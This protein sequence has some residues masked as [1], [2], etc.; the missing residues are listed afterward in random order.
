M[1]NPPAGDGS[2]P[3]PAPVQAAAAAP[4]PSAPAAAPAQAPAPSI[5]APAPAQP[6]SVAAPA[7]APAPSAAAAAPGTPSE[8]K[9]AAHWLLM[10]AR[11]QI[12]L[13]NYDEAMQKVEQARALHIRWG[14]FD[15]TPAKVAQAIERARPKAVAV[16]TPDQPRDR[17]AA[18]ARLKEARALLADGRYEQAEALALDVKGWGLSYGLFEDSPSKVAAAA[19]ALRRREEVRKSGPK[20]QPSQ[21]V[22]EAL[23][24]EARQLMAAGQLDQAEAKA[25]QAQRMNVVPALTA[26][27][28][29]AVLHDLAMARARQAPAGGPG[30]PGG[31]PVGAMAPAAAAEPASAVAER[32]GNVLLNQGDSVCA[33]AKF[34]EAERLRAQE[35]AAQGPAP[36]GGPAPLAGAMPKP[37]ADPSVQKAEGSA[38]APVQGLPAPAPVQELPAPLPGPGPPAPTPME[39]PTE[40]PRAVV[41]ATDAPANGAPDTAQAPAP[42]RGEQLIAE[43]KALYAHGNF[44]AAKEMAAKAKA[45]QQ[46]VDA[47]ADELL[48]QVAQAEQAGA[49]SLYESALDALRKGEHGRARALLTEVAASGSAIDE[50]L[51]QKVQDLLMKLPKE[52]AT[53]K[54][55]ATDV[56]ALMPD[57]EALAAQ[58]L[59]AEVGTMIAEARRLQETDPDKAIALYE[60]T[61]E[62]VKAAE[63]PETLARTMARRIEVNL[64]LAKKE[65][66]AFDAKMQDQ[67]TR[68][69]IEQ[70]RLR[71]LEA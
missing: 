60:Q 61:L 16:A 17:R 40:A 64:E 54:A 42:S 66:I 53:G 69:E 1:T 49:L 39:Q 14:L 7:Q 62:V 37:A 4:A 29:E 35:A 2:V 33:A 65:K 22:Y 68:A 41:P 63:I 46:G 3:D 34:A 58:K 11:E 50:A 30:G 21:G 9:R 57:S 26:D 56:P 51:L 52:D 43:A 36:A 59:N 27:R 10:A 6:P 23:V 5:A 31:Q 13:G 45:T 38:P 25:L 48:A 70:K 15:D 28:A 67:A 47:Q 32:E 55:V 19:R 44:P 8:D 20:E 12:R 71:V 18:R 24:Q